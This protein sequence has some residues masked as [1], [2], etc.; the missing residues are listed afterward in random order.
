MKRFVVP[1]IAHCGKGHAQVL[2]TT[3]NCPPRGDDLVFALARKNQ[4]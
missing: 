3:E 1:R 4:D 2:G